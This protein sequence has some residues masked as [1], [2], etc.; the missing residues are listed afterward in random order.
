LRFS[1]SSRLLLLVG[2]PVSSSARCV[3]ASSATRT[4]AAHRRRAGPGIGHGGALG[5][6]SVF[7]DRASPEDAHLA[8]L[9]RAAAMVATSALSH[10]AELGQLELLLDLVPLL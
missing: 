1:V 4:G 5:R 6:S 9:V 7:P 8:A 3:D 10:Q 2:D